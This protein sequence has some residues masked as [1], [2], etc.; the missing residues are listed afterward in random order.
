MH[1]PGCTSRRIFP[2][3]CSENVE[4]GEGIEYRCE[5]IKIFRARYW[6]L[7]EFMVGTVELKTTETVAKFHDFYFCG[8]IA[9]SDD[10]IPRISRK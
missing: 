1:S 6:C 5:F 7:V 8:C 3:V 4:D 2:F 9:V 10:P